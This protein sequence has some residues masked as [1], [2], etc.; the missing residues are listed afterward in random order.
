MLASQ[1]GGLTTAA[2]TDFMRVKKNTCANASRRSG[3]MAA[4]N[5][6]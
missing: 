3:L 5:A 1:T 2:L 4:P 6:I